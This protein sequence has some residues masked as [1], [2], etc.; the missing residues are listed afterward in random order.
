M[1][2]ISIIS[3]NTDFSRDSDINFFINFTLGTLHVLLTNNMLIPFRVRFLLS[4]L[5]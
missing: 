2:F 3:E 1:F 5:L 4:M